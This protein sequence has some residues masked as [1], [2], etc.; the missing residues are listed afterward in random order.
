MHLYRNGPERPSLQRRFPTVYEYSQMNNIHLLPLPSYYTAETVRLARVVLPWTKI[1]I[2]YFP[3]AMNFR[4]LGSFD[5]T[6]FELTGF[7]R[8]LSQSLEPLGLHAYP[9]KVRILLFDICL[10]RL[11][12]TTSSVNESLLHDPKNYLPQVR[13]ALE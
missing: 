12:G 5:A 4:E 7:M 11:I 9:F 2:F 8:L 3:G 6:S 13:K 10:T 1:K